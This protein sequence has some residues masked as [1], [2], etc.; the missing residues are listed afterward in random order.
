MN[1]AALDLKEHVEQKEVIDRY[2]RYDIVYVMLDKRIDSLGDEIKHLRNE[3]RD[4]FKDVR[5]EIR[6]LRTE[7]TQRIDALS[8]QMV[9]MKTWGIGLLVTIIVIVL[10]PHIAALLG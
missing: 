2:A 4:E 9:S 3:M 6:E 8:G 1:G 5:G 7:T 10:A